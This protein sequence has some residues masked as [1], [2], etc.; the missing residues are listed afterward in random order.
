MS[1]QVNSNLYLNGQQAGVTTPVYASLVSDDINPV[2]YLGT[3][4][5]PGRLIFRLPD[6]GPY[7]GAL[8]SVQVAGYRSELARVTLPIENATEG[9][10]FDLSP[11]N[12]TSKLHIEGLGFK[13]SSG[14]QW[15]WR[16]STDFMLYKRYLAGVDI[17]PILD[18]RVDVGA[19][20]VRVLGMSHYIERFYPQDYP[21]YY[22]QL[23]S[24]ASLLSQNGLYLEFVVFADA[25]IIMKNTSEQQAHFSKICEIIRNG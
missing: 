16:G 9:P 15:W 5:E 12:L 2:T 25:Q 17:Q 19:N 22:N 21:G 24:F 20:L 18:Q 1:R 7:G 3:V 11:L 4:E 6:G 8:I 14:K 23:L 10:S 13:D